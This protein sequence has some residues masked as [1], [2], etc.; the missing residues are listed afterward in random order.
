MKKKFNA[1]VLQLLPGFANVE[2]IF[3]A[4][5]SGDILCGFA[6]ERLSHKLRLWRYVLP[7]YGFGDELHFSYSK[8]V[9]RPND[10]IDLAQKDISDLAEEFVEKTNYYA[11]EL[12]RL[13][14]LQNF[15]VYVENILNV[16]VNHPGYGGVRKLGSPHIRYG[17]ASTLLLLGDVT[18]AGAQFSI[19]RDVLRFYFES[20]DPA[21]TKTKRVAEAIR[22][23]P[24]VEYKALVPSENDIRFISKVDFILDVLD[25]DSAK[26]RSILIDDS[27]FTRRK[28]GIEED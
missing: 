5:V 20:G 19:I 21:L 17:Y 22:C 11:P 8:M 24:K 2:S 7:L 12:M 23:E 28:Y 16:T 18:G 15:L 4:R 6:Y 14:E 3:Y 27:L 25:D 1:K 9:D 13:R 26:A 10:F